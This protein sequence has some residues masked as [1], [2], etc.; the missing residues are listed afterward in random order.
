MSGSS[1]KT[2]DSDQ[3]QCYEHQTQRR[4]RFLEQKDAYDH[5]AQSTD[6]CPDGV[7]SAKGQCLSSLGQKQEA[8]DHANNGED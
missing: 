5:G 4:N 6:S 1:L 8:E 7:R 2:D 3:E